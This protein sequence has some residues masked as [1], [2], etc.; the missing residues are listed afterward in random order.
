[1]S[2]TSST[3]LA[4]RRGHQVSE[5]IFVF[6]MDHGS[7]NDVHLFSMSLLKGDEITHSSLGA[8]LT[9]STQERADHLGIKVEGLFKGGH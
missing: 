8:E 4:Q 3:W 6:T 7:H 1:M 5:V 2:T 9:V